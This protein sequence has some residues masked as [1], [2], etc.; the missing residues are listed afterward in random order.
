LRENSLPRAI[1][2]GYKKARQ[3]TYRQ[4]AC[5]LLYAARAKWFRIKARFGLNRLDNA[6]FNESAGTFTQISGVSS[7]CRTRVPA[8]HATPVSIVDHFANRQVRFFFDVEDEPSLAEQYSSKEIQNAIERAD[9]VRNQAFHFR[10]T[11]FHFPGEIDWDYTAN[12][13]R[14]WTRDLNRLFFLN[15]LGRAYWYCRDPAYI[16][17]VIQ[18]TEDWSEKHP[19][20]TDIELWS[21]VLEVAIRLGVLCWTWFFLLA[22]VVRGDVAV[23]RAFIVLKLIWLHASY[24]HTHIEVH[25]WGNHLLLEAKALAMAGILFPEFKEAAKWK[26][27]GWY[28]LRRELKSQV[29]A[30]GVHSEQSSMYHKIITSEL[31]ELYVLHLRNDWPVPLWL[32]S[33]LEKM[34][35][36]EMHLTKPDGTFPVLG[37]SSL[38]DLLLRYR[39]L[40]TGAVIFGRPD[41]KYVSKK[42]LGGLDEETKWLIGPDLATDYVRMTTTQPSPPSA[43]FKDGGFYVMRSDWSAQAN[44]LMVDGGPFGYECAP[45]HGHADALSIE[46]TW[47]GKSYIVDSGAFDYSLPGDWREYFRGTA[48]HST[49]RI[50]HSNQTDLHNAF[51]AFGLAKTTL[52]CWKSTSEFDF[53]DLSHAGYKSR[54]GVIHRRQ[55]V[56]AKPDVWLIRDLL[57]GRGEHVIEWLWHFSPD[58][59][60][61][62]LERD[63]QVSVSAGDDLEQ[64]G[65]V[66]TWRTKLALEMELLKG[67]TRPVQGWV[68]ESF[69]RRRAALVLRVGGRVPLPAEVVTVFTGDDDSSQVVDVAILESPNRNG[70][71]VRIDQSSSTF[72]VDFSGSSIDKLGGR[73]IPLI[74]RTHK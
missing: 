35:D 43:A 58:V 12:G 4:L 51:D 59:S 56:F 73:Q 30:D 14:D 21:D 24:L 68:S 69:G 15:D 66:V 63:G 22:A 57:D 16:D 31:T 19:V 44:S 61:A 40:A 48:G 18:L 32:R 1:M 53:L 64:S 34:L 37:D 23:Q 36:F 46:L 39:A 41:F 55:I 3:K 70:T 33:T 26:A 60:V 65:L 9:A 54:F 7:R 13:Y 17:K 20:R 8:G 47:R 27:R 5:R 72:F 38:Q 29:R 62:S 2:R 71:T 11:A 52:H 74:R 6:A 45:A 42:F 49:V 25:N 10:E 67:E 28:H 50:N